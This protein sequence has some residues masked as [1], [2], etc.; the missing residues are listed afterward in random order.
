MARTPEKQADEL[1]ESILA[2]IRDY[3]A[4]HG[5]SP[6]MREIGAYAGIDNVSHIQFYIK[7][8]VTAGKIRHEP[9]VAR[10]IV[11]IQ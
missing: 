6:S 1:S 10:S 2:F 11:V 9:R 5:Y 4:K 3:Q 7:R 8:L